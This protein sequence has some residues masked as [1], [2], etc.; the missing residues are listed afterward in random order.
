MRTKQRRIQPRPE[1][2]EGRELLAAGP[3][4]INAGIPEFVDAIKDSNDW[5]GAP[6]DS[7]GWPTTDA[8]IVVLDDRVNQPWNGPD[9]NASVPNMSGTYHLSFTG[10]ADVW[11]WPASVQDQ[12]YDPATNTTTADVV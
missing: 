1:S 2:L 10:R 4:G 8:T 3:L 7:R 6:V 11:S 5:G 12:S 9:P